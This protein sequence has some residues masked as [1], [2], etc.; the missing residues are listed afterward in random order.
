LILKQ[1][2]L[3]C[4]SQA[5][6]L[7]GDVES[8][9]AVVVDPRR[10]VLDYVED[11]RELGLEIRAV[12]LTHFHADFV[13]GHLELAKLT[14]A[15]IHLGRRAE[16]DFDFVPMSD[17][18]QLDLGSVRLEVIETPGHTPESICILVGVQ[19]SR[20]QEPHALLTGDTLFIGDVGRPDLMASEG[21]VASDLAGDL[22]ESLRKLMT[23]PDRT[24][25]YPGHGAGSMC[26]KNLSTES[27]STIGEQRR[28][29]P[30]LQPMSREEFVRLV[31]TDL[32]LAP[33]YFQHDAK[34]NRK[35][36]VTLEESLERSLVPLSL[37]EVLRAAEDGGVILD[38]REPGPYCERHL[39]GS[40]NIGL[41]GTYAIWAGTIL[42]P[43]R[44]I[45]VLADPGLER[46]ATLR[47]GRIG[48]DRVA[49]YLDHPS[50]AL[51]R[52]P[53]V[54][55]SVERYA[56]EDLAGRLKGAEPPLLLDVR[57]IKERE[58]MLIPASLH[59]PLNRLRSSLKQIPRGR[60]IVAYCRSGYRSSI[61]ASLLRSCGYA[62]ARDLVGGIEAWEEAGHEIDHQGV[63]QR[64]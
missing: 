28:L 54:V 48:F 25:V 17:G 16:A 33:E 63:P 35:R 44:V 32:P 31:S 41:S 11:A 12:F 22:Y 19:K 5:S 24:L 26:G 52:R 4:L 53:E 15:R 50:E 64:S 47:L 43:D 34:L 46:E 56:P 45:V 14:G 61:A 6:Y 58:E 1:Y 18:M 10:D 42:D 21:C 30:A 39:R 20:G 38:V 40:I 49:G 55:G 62:N 59:V 3:G 36:R 27:V 9:N 23:L 13:A 2:Y 51:A 37:G 60:P 29:N 7:I 57:G 8:G